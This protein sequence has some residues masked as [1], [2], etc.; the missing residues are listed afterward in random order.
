[1]ATSESAARVFVGTFSTS[2]FPANLQIR[3]FVDQLEREIIEISEREQ[4][5]IGR[6]LHDGL[7]HVMPQMMAMSSPLLRSQN[8]T[9]A[10]IGAP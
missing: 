6:D 1:L 3:L 8:Q 5:R 2:G 7:C 4:R 10:M 9:A